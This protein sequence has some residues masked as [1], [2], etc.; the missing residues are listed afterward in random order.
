MANAK[1]ETVGWLS[2]QTLGWII[3]SVGVIGLLVGIGFVI[4]SAYQDLLGYDYQGLQSVAHY[5]TLTGTFAYDT[6]NLIASRTIYLVGFVWSSWPALIAAFTAALALAVW[7][8]YPDIHKWLPRSLREKFSATRPRPALWIPR[9]AIRV[10]LYI[11]FLT[12]FLWLDAPALHVRQLLTSGFDTELAVSDGTILETRGKAVWWDVVCWR[13]DPSHRAGSP[14]RFTAC[15]EQPEEHRNRLDDVFLVNVA[16]L[17]FFATLLFRRVELERAKKPS[18]DGPWAT[19]TPL[20]ALVVVVAVDACALAYVYAKTIRSTVVSEAV[21]SIPVSENPEEVTD[22][23]IGSAVGD[24]R[25][26]VL[27]T[28][29]TDVTRRAGG[30]AAGAASM[31]GTASGGWVYP[32]TYPAHGYILSRGEDAIILFSKTEWQVWIVPKDKIALVRIERRADVVAAYF[33][34]IAEQVQKPTG[35]PPP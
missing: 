10:L 33:A 5:A 26:T 7:M 20:S 17:A 31:G 13:L 9:A 32:N 8:S 34:S 15:N 35:A 28:G 11:L 27:G 1:P 19:A 25:G 14:N 24:T 29:S 30:I 12:Q 21:I 22:S 18:S 3:G 2:T 4:D 16:L 6:F 23:T